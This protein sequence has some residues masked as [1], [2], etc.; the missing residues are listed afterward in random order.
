MAKNVAHNS[1]E[2]NTLPIYILVKTALSG[3]VYDNRRVFLP[4]TPLKNMF[5]DDP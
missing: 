4:C 3:K 1:R 5:F 2:A